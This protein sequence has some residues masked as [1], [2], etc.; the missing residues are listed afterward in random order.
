MDKLSLVNKKWVIVAVKLYFWFFKVL[1]EV[2]SL[3][4]SLGW[5]GGL[6]RGIRGTIGVKVLLISSTLLK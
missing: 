5:L 2:I 4:I 1:K 6:A 3:L